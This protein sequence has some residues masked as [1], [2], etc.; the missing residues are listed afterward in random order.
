V[1]LSPDPPHHGRTMAV[2]VTGINPVSTS[3]GR[4]RVA[5]L[6]MGFK[7]Y[8]YETPLCEAVSCP[9]VAGSD[10]QLKVSQKLPALAPPGPYEMEISGEDTAGGVFMCVSISFRVSM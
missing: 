1:T 8:T 10:F 9:L 4:L 7:V 2:N 5:V 6:Y 3:G